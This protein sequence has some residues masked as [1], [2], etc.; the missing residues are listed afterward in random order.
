[1]SSCQ[2]LG[3]AF[4]GTFGFLI[5]GELI[6]VN[7]L[8]LVDS[9]LNVPAR[10]VAAISSRE[11]TRAESADWRSLPVAIVNMSGVKS[12]LFCPG[13]GERQTDGAL[14]CGFGNSVP[15][16]REGCAKKNDQ[17]KYALCNLLLHCKPPNRRCNRLVPESWQTRHAQ[18]RGAMRDLHHVETE[19]GSYVQMLGLLHLQAF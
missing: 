3:Y 17:Q 2:H 19:F 9:I 14:P 12:R 4:R 15:C 16:K 5:H 10:E 13:I 7:R 6:C 1:M 8:I 11:G 18:D